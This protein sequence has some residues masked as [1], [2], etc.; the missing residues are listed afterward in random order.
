MLDGLDRVRVR[1]G[2]GGTR[3]LGPT[4]GLGF[5]RRCR[6]WRLR[7]GAL[8]GTQAGAGGARGVPLQT[9]DPGQERRH[10]RIDFGRGR[11][12]QHELK[13]DP[14]LGAVGGR[15][16]RGRDEVEQADRVGGGQRGGLLG[17]TDVAL[18]GDPKLGRHVAQHLHREQL[19]TVDLEVAQELAG[20]PARVGEVRRGPKRP[21]GIARNDRVDRLEQLLGVGHPEH[22]KHVDRLDRPPPGVGEELLE[23]AQG[24]AEAS[25]GVPRDQRH[26]TFLDLDPLFLSHALQHG[27]HLLD[28]RPSEVEP[29]APVDHGREYLL[30]LGRG[31]HE[32][33]PRGRLL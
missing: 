3:S 29:V 15:L 25:G 9:L 28:G 2:L 31:Q 22:R 18:R 32:D 24:V 6:R 10:R 12:D 11:L 5:R 1:R 27:R 16:E 7:L 13:L 26:R 20:V 30:R 14:S 8:R 23:R 33:R 21:S 4:R 17:Q 19:A